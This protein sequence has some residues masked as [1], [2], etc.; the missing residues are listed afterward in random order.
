MSKKFFPIRTETSCQLKWN[1]STIFLNT[2]TTRSCCRTG[3]SEL[4]A[5]NFQDFHNT[6]IK[7]ADR[8]SM[9]KGEWPE[10]SCGYCKDIEAAGG[11]SDRTRHLT[12]PSLVPAELETNSTAIQIDPTIVEVYFSNAC[13]LGCVYCSAQLSST[14]EAEDRKFGTLTTENHFK[15]LVP[16]FWEWFATGF[17]KVKRLHILG[18]EPLYQKEFDK[19]LDMI[20]QYPNPDCE[21]NIVT[22]LMVS[23]ERLQAYVDRFKELLVA[24]KLKRVDITCS[25]DCAGPEQ[26]YVR[27]G[28]NWNQWEENFELL[29]KHRWLYLTINQTISA[30][31][32]KTM[33]EF[34]V[35]FA[36]WRENRKI[37]HWFSGIYPD[38]SYMKAEIFG[39]LEFAEDAK[40]V[41][42]L[43]PRVT[44]ED[45][46]AYNYMAGI[47]AQ[48][49]A[50]T[51]N[52]NEIAKLIV[53]L[54]EK[55]RRRGTSW[56]ELF[57]W[58]ERYRKYVV[59]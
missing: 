37:G 11:A 45:H 33:P 47:F 25:I 15:D 21:L 59:Q 6:P 9:L 41:L 52:Y 28:L 48:I 40:K 39:D 13:N 57:P 36:K 2:G 43:L 38:P 30:L 17:S 51:P 12:I 4:T 14:I 42:Q 10:R 55:D 54:D 24:R 58:L 29:M 5:E 35:K 32:I 49:L 1:W 18:G 27:Y 53:F 56:P 31:T 46:V 26:E 34:L 7:L 20:D 16:Y 44:E 3:E 19:L 50:S 22:N 23:T 8:T